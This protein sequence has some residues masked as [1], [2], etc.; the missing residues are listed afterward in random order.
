VNVAASPPT[1]NV[2]QAAPA[3]VNFEAKQIAD[4]IR[5]LTDAVKANMAEMVMIRAELRAQA[6]AVASLSDAM[7]AP[8]TLV[9]EN[10]KPVGVR[11]GKN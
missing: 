11:I 7:V 6:D 4:A 8:R 3:V 10:G 9:M 5:S 1:I 2:A